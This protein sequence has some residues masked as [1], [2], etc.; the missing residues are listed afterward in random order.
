M[1]VDKEKGRSLASLSWSAALR[2]GLWR[3]IGTRHPRCSKIEL[4]GKMKS[5]MWGIRSRDGVTGR[6]YRVDKHCLE[7]MKFEVLAGP[8]SGQ[9]WGAGDRVWG[10]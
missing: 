10:N 2:H 5:C 7:Q 3:A 8:L 9:K 1:S 4:Q 6:E